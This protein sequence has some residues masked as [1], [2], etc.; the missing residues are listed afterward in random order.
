MAEESAAAAKRREAAE[1]GR[2]KLDEFRARKAAGIKAKQESVRDSASVASSASKVDAPNGDTP[3]PPPPIPAKCEPATACVESGAAS[4]STGEV[5]ASPPTQTEP[6]AAANPSAQTL[7]G[8]GTQPACSAASVP[9][10]TPPPP[11]PTP[12]QE[13]VASKGPLHLCLIPS[14]ALL[15]PQRWGTT[16]RQIK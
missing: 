15:A 3:P 13:S 16:K 14:R 4:S 12:P 6:A 1:K 11:P 10:T 8:S 7:Q 5:D 9:M 2:R